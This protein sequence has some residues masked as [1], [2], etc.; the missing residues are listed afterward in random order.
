MDDTAVLSNRHHTV[1]GAMTDDDGDDP[2]KSRD[3][4]SRLNFSPVEDGQS[5][6]PYNS[7]RLG[8][9]DKNRRHKHDVCGHRLSRM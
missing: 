8:R 1:L 4:Y 2:D 9:D 3:R 5:D 6:K 7:I